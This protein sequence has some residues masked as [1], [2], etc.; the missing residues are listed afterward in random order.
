MSILT[1]KTITQLPNLITPTLNTAL[2]AQEGNTTYNV[3][4]DNLANTLAGAEP[5]MNIS[6]NYYSNPQFITE[7]IQIP[8]N[9]NALIVGPTISLASGVTINVP[10]NSV[11]TIL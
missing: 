9:S 7:D 11:L 6:A 1:G 5:F 2:P 4:V 10:L 8:Q 3:T